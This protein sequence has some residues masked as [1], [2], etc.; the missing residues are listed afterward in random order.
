MD[1][2]SLHDQPDLTAKALNRR[3]A[4]PAYFAAPVLVEEAMAEGDL[5]FLRV[6]T[7]TGQL[8]EITVESQELEIALAA[9][10]EGT[11]TMVPAED[12]FLLIESARIRL[13]YAFDPY[14]AVSLSGIAPLPHQLEA[15]YE[16]MLP[17]V[18][19]RYLLA[20]DP[21]AGKTIMAGLL[22]K[23]LKMR[24]AIERVLVLCPA[25]LTIQWQDELRS[26]FDEVFE[27][28]RSE[29]AKDQLAGNVWDR[30][31]QCIASIDFAKQDDVWPG[32]LR[33]H[34]DLVVIDE[35]HKCAART[36]GREVKKT[37]RYRLGE[38]LSAGAER[39]LL[40]TATPHQGDPDQFAHFLRLLD[41]DQFVDPHRV[42]GYGELNKDLLRLD[43]NP[44]F[45]RRMKEEL[46]DFEGRKLFTERHPVT[47][48]FELSGEEIYLYNE[49]TRYINT[50]L[51]RQQRGRRKMSVALARTVLQRRLASSLRAIRRSLERRH[52]R[53]S[54]LLAELQGLTP[55]EQRQRLHELQLL[56]MDEEQGFDDQE[57]EAQDEAATRVTAAE[58]IEDLRREVRELERL[59]ELAKTTEA[60]GEETK[61]AALR[62]CLER[63]EFAELRDGRGKL[64]IFTEHRDTLNYLRENLEAW[65]YTCCEIRGGMNAQQR[66]AAQDTFRRDV[67]VCVAT[68]AAG[69]GIN[70]QFCHLMIN[71]DM[72]WN[73]VRLEQRMGR[74]HRIGQEYDVY[75]F[76]F[77]AVN[78]VEG[79]ILQRL[80]LK[81][82]EMRQAL[83]SRVFDVI[84]LVLKLNDVNLEE[85]LREAAY[86]PR[87][88]EEYEDQIQRIS[89]DRL[90]ELEEATGIAMATSHVDFGRIQ[91]QDYRSEERRLMPEY[92]ESFFLKAADAVGLQVQPRA[93]ALWRAD[94]VPERFRS[95]NLQAVKRFGPPQ[96]SYRKL[97]FYKEHLQ[98]TQHLDAELLSPGH[99]LFAAVT[100]VLE[101]RLAHA[102]QAVAT[103]LD[104][105]TPT[106]YRLHFFEVQVLGERVAPTGGPAR[107]QLQHATLAVVLEEADGTLEVA[108]P[109]IL[110]DLT[111]ITP[112]PRPSGTLSSLSQT[113]GEGR[114]GQGEW[115]EGP[116]PNV[117]ELQH[118]ERW[119]RVNVQHPLVQ[120]RRAEREREIQIRREYLE[121]SFTA[122]IRAQQDRWAALAARVAA[123]E[124][125]AKL[126]RDEALKRV[127]ELEA[128]LRDKL[129]E[130]DHL[131]VLRPGPVTY[132]GTAVVRPAE[133]ERVA[134][135]MR[136]D[137]EVERAAM[138]MA[139]AH[140]RERGWEPEDISRRRDGSGF[141]IRSLGPAD[142][143]GRRP[144][145][146]IEVKGRAGHDEPVVLTPNEWL[147]ARRHGDT[148]WLYVVWGCK[149]GEP[150]LLTIQNP[151]RVLA[152]QAQPLTVVKG[153]LLPAEAI[154]AM[155]EV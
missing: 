16:H 78:T 129:A 17:Q 82:N 128:R 136:R 144:V 104:P 6:R 145:R 73:P 45:L 88:L 61:L 9:A 3:I 74:I 7:Q 49:V 67:Q 27:I 107:S 55:A 130:L 105:T 10:L 148:Y 68:E 53:F 77:V 83:G 119:V 8:E 76:N 18:R 91:Q 110:H 117:G 15:V 102:R 139:M 152:R 58:R 21:G 35:A 54:K 122:S 147:Q 80:L 64:L 62:D 99:P 38:R 19:L 39:L 100:E 44:W 79:R 47:V 98:Q 150:R 65:G 97:T 85:M 112:H 108:P 13:A 20:D 72:P 118:I 95:P 51:P 137:D 60:L 84:G 111:A 24:G 11:V 33:A 28:I 29:L 146:R 154:V 12:F 143:Y 125:A 141:D 109:D 43:G 87:R 138:E 70:L 63:A 57:E 56:V 34:W 153:Y 135:L 42:E 90:K 121:K 22:M 151:A 14:F 127:E 155:V 131:R 94:Y 140:E 96:S 149:T 5:Y 134:T 120:E 89:P 52:E 2:V 30:F 59:I 40:L 114:G 92:V 93:D 116:G 37:Q 133:D 1:E 101:N 31:P 26:K 25:P 23:E 46:R 48:T 81:L 41:A 126:A 106:P 75:I 36:Y 86:N 132:L 50:F 142:E 115:D 103:F 4:L 123:G 124:E 66:K 69:E 113:L 71:Y 32:I